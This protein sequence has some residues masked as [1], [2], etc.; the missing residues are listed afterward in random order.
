MQQLNPVTNLFLAVLAGLGLLGSLTLP[1]YAAAKV[2]P[3]VT[4]GPIERAAWQVGH[5]FSTEA[6]GQ[7]DGA[8]ALGG[9]RVTVL[10]IVALVAVLALAVSL[11]LARRHAE[12]LLRMVAIAAPFA[13]LVVAIVHPGTGEAD[14]SVHYGV[15]VGFAAMLLC[16]NAA[17]HGAAWREKRAAPAR[18]RYGVM[19]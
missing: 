14:V 11:N 18:P 17:Y 13:L 3:N 10:V 1:W 2:S 15:F 5:V 6:G 9:A 8:E 12:D 19:R 16:S 4:D 7:I